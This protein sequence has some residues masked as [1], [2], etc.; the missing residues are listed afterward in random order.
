MPAKVNSGGDTPDNALFQMSKAALE[1]IAE[2]RFRTELSA[3]SSENMTQLLQTRDLTASQQKIVKFYIID[4][5]NQS[6]A[7]VLE[8]AENRSAKRKKNTPRK[9]RTKATTSAASDNGPFWRGFTEWF[10]NI[11]PGALI[12]RRTKD[13]TGQRQR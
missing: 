10:S 8:R 4:A 7:D 5:R 2:T 13:A 1:R 12:K 3:L 6:A 11:S 9:A